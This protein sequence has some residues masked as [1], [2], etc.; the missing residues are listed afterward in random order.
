MQDSQKWPC[1]NAWNNG[2][3]KI[4]KEKSCDGDGK[5]DGDGREVGERCQS[6][7]NPGGKSGRKKAEGENVGGEG[8]RVGG[9]VCERKD[10]DGH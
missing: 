7:L 8:V 5:N 9:S 3:E 1:L 2:K 10:G 6:A 4:G